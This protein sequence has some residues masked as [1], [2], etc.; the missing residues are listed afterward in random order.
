MNVQNRGSE[1]QEEVI[2]Q[3]GALSSWSA[4]AG[5]QVMDRTGVRFCAVPSAG[6]ASC[7]PIRELLPTFEEQ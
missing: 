6:F 7:L 3:Q 2:K 4:E 1:W 5:M